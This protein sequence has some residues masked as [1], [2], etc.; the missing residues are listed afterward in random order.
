MHLAESWACSN[1]PVSPPQIQEA[2]ATAGFKAQIEK[3]QQ[4]R[5]EFQRMVIG[6]QVRTVF[7]TEGFLSVSLVSSSRW[8]PCTHPFLTTWALLFSN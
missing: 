5:D 4:E 2:K 8:S 7:L 3:L 6:N 1:V